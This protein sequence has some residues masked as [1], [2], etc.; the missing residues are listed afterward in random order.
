MPDPLLW[1]PRR[2]PL[3]GGR[4]K[5]TEEHQE[6]LGFWE[7]RGHRPRNKYIEEHVATHLPR[8][9]WCEVCMMGRGRTHQRRKKKEA[10]AAEH[11]PERGVQ[12]SLP[13]GAQGE[14][15]AEGEPD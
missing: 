6:N 5:P 7:C 15:A 4:A 9:P 3:A 10:V 12:L 1:I 8:Q 13:A 2:V 11:E 14:E